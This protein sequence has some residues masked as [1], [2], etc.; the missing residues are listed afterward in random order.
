MV[1]RPVAMR[2]NFPLASLALLVTVAACL[3]ACTD[4]ERLQ[5]QFQML[6]ARGP[7]PAI[8]TFGGGALFGAFVGF[9]YLIA[10]RASWRAR[11]L[12]PLAGLFAG[13]IGIMI[14][15]APGPIWRTTFAVGVLLTAA[16]LFRLG[17]E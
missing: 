16:V 11:S 15:L 1:E 5:M 7:L 17:A 4:A 9:V 12:A 14:L 3:L 13:M 6:T 2:S 8:F 10:G